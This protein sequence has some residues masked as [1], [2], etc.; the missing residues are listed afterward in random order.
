MSSD[1]L[2]PLQKIDLKLKSFI[3]EAKEDCNFDPSK[4]QTFFNVTA[5]HIKW[6]K[7]LCEWQKLKNQLEFEKS[8]QYKITLEYFIKE[9]PLK[10]SNKEQLEALINADLKYDAIKQQTL[11]VDNVIKFISETMV[12][13]KS[14]AYEVNRYIEWQKFKNG[15]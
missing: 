3:E 14:K 11:A 6:L 7:Y 10:V 5:T 8:K 12:I 13:V 2:T 1:E 4:E 9:Y 15:R